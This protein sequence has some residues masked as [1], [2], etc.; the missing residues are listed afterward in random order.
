MNTVERFKKVLGF[1]SF[2][3][4]PMIEWAQFWDKTVARWRDE[5][6]GQELCENHEICQYF[7]LDNYR[8]VWLSPLKSSCPLPEDGN[9]GMIKNIDEYLRLKEHLYPENG[10]DKELLAKWKPMHE[11]GEM[12][13]WFLV[14]GFFWFPRRLLGIERHLY[15]FYDDP[16]LM[17]LINSDVLEYNLRVIKEFCCFCAPSFMQFG[18]DMS[19]NHGPMLSKK[20]FD[21]FIAPYYRKIVPVIKELGVIPLIDTDGDVAPCIPWFREVGIEGVVPLERMAGVDVVQIRKENPGFIFV[22]GFDKMVM[23]LGEEA[24]RK[25]FERLLPVMKDGGYLL[26]VDHQT[27]PEVSLEQYRLYVSLLR[28][29]CIKAAG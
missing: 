17:H 24:M 27:P 22:G 10:F 14:E 21:E 1:E 6:L 7:G 20:C 11:S 2:D 3:R 16:E 25:E 4:L 18:E 15:A 9:I 19:Y 28:E 23:H 26:S 13:I 8:Q 12:A 5:G 29:Y